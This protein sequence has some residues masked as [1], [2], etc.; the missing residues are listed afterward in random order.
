M[1][2]FAAL[3][4]LSVIALGGGWWPAAAWNGTGH[5]VGAL[6]AWDNLFAGGAQQ[7]G[8]H[9]APG[10]RSQLRQLFRED[11]RPLTCPRA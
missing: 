8:G 7:G 5:E 4:S 11:G 3:V 9:H 1:K 6:I 10:A 2:A